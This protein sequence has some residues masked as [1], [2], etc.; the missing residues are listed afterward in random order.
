MRNRLW[1][2]T[3]FLGHKNGQHFEKQTWFMGN[4]AIWRL[5]DSDNSDGHEDF[6]KEGLLTYYRKKL[7]SLNL[8]ERKYFK[9]LNFDLDMYQLQEHY[10]GVN[11]RQA[12]DHKRYFLN[13]LSSILLPALLYTLAL[14]HQ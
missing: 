3:P 7:W 4:V 1:S 10:P 2:S 9:A 8:L 11:C 12:Y 13:P 6:N 14:L 5:Y